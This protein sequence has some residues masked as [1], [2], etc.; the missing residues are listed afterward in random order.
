MCHLYAVR[1]FLRKRKLRLFVK[2][3]VSLSFFPLFNLLFVCKVCQVSPRQNSLHQFFPLILF[4]L[5]VIS[6]YFIS[7]KYGQ[8]NSR[9]PFN[10]I[11]LIKLTF[12]C[13]G[14]ENLHFYTP[15]EQELKIWKLTSVCLALM[16]KCKFCKNKGSESACSSSLT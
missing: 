6:K 10:I 9:N 15:C 1:A 2:T 11:C 8:E 7:S 3:Y 14:L 5:P 16:N 4:F 12:I 13:T